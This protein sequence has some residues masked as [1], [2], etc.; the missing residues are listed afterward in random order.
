MEDSAT[1]RFAARIR[2]RFRAAGVSNLREFMRSIGHGTDLISNLVRGQSDDIYAGKLA[3]AAI[4]A[5]IPPSEIF[6]EL[7]KAILYPPVLGS[8]NASAISLRGWPNDYPDPNR[9]AVIADTVMQYAQDHP[10]TRDASEVGEMVAALYSEMVTVHPGI[11]HMEL[12]RR[13][14]AFLM[15]ID[16]PNPDKKPKRASAFQS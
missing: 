5:N 16:L 15:G 11:P 9:L 4:M 7:E 1:K 2:D 10:M 12:R 14:F 6:A 8:D 3:H 13:V